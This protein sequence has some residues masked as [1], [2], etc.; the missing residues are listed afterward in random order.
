MFLVKEETKTGQIAELSPPIS[1]RDFFHQ[2][3]GSLRKEC[4]LDFN[5]IY[6]FSVFSFT[7]VR[8]LIPDAERPSQ[9]QEFSTAVHSGSD[10]TVR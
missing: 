9:S 5:S 6:W 4:I 8:A 1:V 2:R 10:A 7:C 3:Y